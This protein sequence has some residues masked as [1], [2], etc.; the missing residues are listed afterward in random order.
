METVNEILTSKYF[1]HYPNGYVFLYTPY[2]ESIIIRFHDNGSIYLLDTTIGFN[3]DRIDI[4]DLL[5]Y[6]QDLLIDFAPNDNNYFSE[7]GGNA[8]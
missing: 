2:D 3:Y 8:H 7:N 1:K 5:G 4:E 6:L